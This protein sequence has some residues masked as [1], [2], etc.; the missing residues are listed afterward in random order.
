[1]LCKFS[2]RNLKLIICLLCFQ[3]CIAQNTVIVGRNDTISPASWPHPFQ[4]FDK[5]F[6]SQILFHKAELFTLGITE[7]A[8]ITSLGWI[9]ES[10]ALNGHYIEDY[11]I[12]LL[13]TSVTEMGPTNFE[14]GATLVYGPQDYSYVSG[15]SGQIL[16]PVTPFVYAGENLIIEYCGG[17]ISG[18]TSGEPNIQFS[19]DFPE[20]ISHTWHSNT[21][22]CCGAPNYNW[23]FYLW[24]PVTV[25]TFTPGPHPFELP[26]IQG[27]VYYDANQNGMRDGG[28]LG[29]PNQYVEITP[30][31]AYGLTNS[32]GHYTFYADTDSYSY[33][34]NSMPPWTITS[35]PAAYND[36][37]PP[38][39]SGKDFGIWAPPSDLDYTQTVGYVTGMMRCNAKGYSTINLLNSGFVPENGTVTLLFSNNLNFD[40]TTSTSGYSVI[41]NSIRWSYSNLMPGQ[42][43]MINGNF[44]NGPAGDTVLFTYVDSVFDASWNFQRAYSNSFS[45]AIRCSFDPNDKAVDPEGIGPEH[46]TL[47]SEEL[48]YTIR[49]QNTG[50]DT[51]FNIM[52]LDTLDE[53]LDISTFQ[54]VASSHPL[55]VQI[56]PDR[57]VRFAFQNI[58]LPDSIV[59]EPSSHGYVVYTIKPNAGLIDGTIIENTAHILFDLN[60]AIVTNTTFN[61]MVYSIPMNIEGRNLNFGGRIF[62]N[63]GTGGVWLHLNTP[64]EEK[65]FL[66]IYNTIGEVVLSKVFLGTKIFISDFLNPGMYIL[67][68]RNASGD[69][70]YNTKLNRN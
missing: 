8:V 46:Y 26:T 24:R 35:L 9:L 56:N 64:S 28:E 18:T 51:A 13:N 58:L 67:Q 22:Q 57:M 39:E 33:G 2:I 14:P 49:F 23:G 4:D 48:L 45:I 30:P 29:L 27:T 3:D 38:S 17:D 11:S 52:V 65:H 44:N 36:Y 1:M 32:T 68:V 20:A 53:D 42:Q 15:S 40:D 10:T 34:W 12:Y 66:K 19:I 31:G 63:P 60:P 43:I 21:D 55:S 69:L 7:G 41:G 5:S 54:V 6:R 61:T 50:N 25:F 37:V 16:F 70:I 59:D 62:P 47:M